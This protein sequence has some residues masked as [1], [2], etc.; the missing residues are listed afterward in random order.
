MDVRP[1]MTI[2][3]LVS[4]VYLAVVCVALDEPFPVSQTQ[5]GSSLVQA[6]VC[7]LIAL[8]ISYA[9]TCEPPGFH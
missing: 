4:T 9:H 3:L 1:F 2:S 6:V 7:Q 5:V 8:S